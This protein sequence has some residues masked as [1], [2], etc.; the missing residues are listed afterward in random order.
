[1]RISVCIFTYLCKWERNEE[2]GEINLGGFSRYIRHVFVTGV[3][4]NG[5]DCI[6][7]IKIP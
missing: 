1:M 3:V 2:M 6:D 7:F 4:I 5:F